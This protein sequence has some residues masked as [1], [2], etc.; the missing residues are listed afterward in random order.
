M[1]WCPVGGL[2]NRVYVCVCVCVCVCVEGRG[3]GGPGKRCIENHLMAL[4]PIRPQWARSE[5]GPRAVLPKGDPTPRAFG[6]GLWQNCASVRAG[7]ARSPDGKDLG[8][9]VGATMSQFPGHRPGNPMHP[10]VAR[11]RSDASQATHPRQLTP[12][13]SP[14]I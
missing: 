5:T 14:K 13:P 9:E 8:T 7:S 4:H 3:Q 11:C 10:G 12:T 2:R 6:G 1:F